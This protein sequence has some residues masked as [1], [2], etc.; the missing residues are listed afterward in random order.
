M[1]SKSQEDEV[2]TT[3][4]LCHDYIQNHQRLSDEAIEPKEGSN[5]GSLI[6]MCT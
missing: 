4:P 3:L 2:N 1:P 6:E 5:L